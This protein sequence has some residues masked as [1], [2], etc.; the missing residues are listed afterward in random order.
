MLKMA[1][2]EMEQVCE[3]F[4]AP[5]PSPAGGSAAAAVAAIAASLVVM[6][7]RGSPEWAQ[8]SEAAA[9][10]S[11][12]RDRLL[13]LAGEDVEAVAAALAAL[14]LLAQPD[15]NDE[16]VVVGA[17][18]H[19]SK[20][21]LEIGECAADVAALARS[22]AVNGQRPMRVDAGAA[23]TLAV[24]AA[25]VAASIVNANVASFPAGQAREERATLLEAA[26]LLSERVTIRPPELTGSDQAGAG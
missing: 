7:G 1:S 25:Q 4:A 6:V 21:P 5:F 15:A 9:S 20:V 12:L 26:K 14:R 17:L 16:P 3:R 13:I 10:A 11:A 18:L 8:G 2:L 24:A 19:A 23:T 22:G